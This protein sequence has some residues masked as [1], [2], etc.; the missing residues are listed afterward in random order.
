VGVVRRFLNTG[1]AKSTSNMWKHTKK[2][3]TAEVVAS[4][5]KSENANDVCCTTVKGLLDPQSI[6]AA[7]EQKG[8]GKVTYSHR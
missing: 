8:K 2:C 3:W 6:M 1:D 7:F 5:D 4:T